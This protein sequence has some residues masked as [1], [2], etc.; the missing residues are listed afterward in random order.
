MSHLNGKR[1]LL[2]E[3]LKEAHK[4][5]RPPGGKDNLVE[6]IVITGMQNGCTNV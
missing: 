4:K 2:R 3:V 6:E 1:C 5:D